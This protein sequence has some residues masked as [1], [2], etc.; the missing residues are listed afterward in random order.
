MLIRGSRLGLLAELAAAELL[1]GRLVRLS[2]APGEL[3]RAR[4]VTIERVRR[5]AAAE[6]VPGALARLRCCEPAQLAAGQYLRS[7]W[8]PTQAELPTEAELRRD[9]YSLAG[10][11]PVHL[12]E[13]YGRPAPD[14]VLDELLAVLPAGTVRYRLAALVEDPAGGWPGVI[15][16]VDELA[17]ELDGRGAAGMP[18]TVPPRLLPGLPLIRTADAADALLR[19]A[20]QPATGPYRVV[21]AVAT[22]GRT[23]WQL[24][25]TGLQLPIAQ[26]PAAAA[27]LTELLERRL[28]PLL[29]DLADGRRSDVA[30]AA[31]AA[32]P[33]PS[34]AELAA[35]IDEVRIE[36][37]RR[38]RTRDHAA[39]RL[40]P[41]RP[42][43]TAGGLPYLVAGEDGLAVVVVNALGQGPAHWLPFAAEWQPRRMLVWQPAPGHTLAEQVA[44][45]TAVLAAEGI[46]RCCLLAWCS[47]A[48]VATRFWR[49]AAQR[50]SALVLLAADFRDRQRPAELDSVYEKHLDEIFSKLIPRPKLADRMVGMLNQQLEPPTAEEA[51]FGPPAAL[52]P[53]IRAPFASGATLLRYAGQLQEFWAAEELPVAERIRCPVLSIIGDRDDIV[54]P[55][56]AAA[57]TAR[58][59]TARQL[60]V[61]GGTHYLMYE[62]PELV[63]AAL[64]EFL[65]GQPASAEC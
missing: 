59:P 24:L 25:L 45:L 48:K 26:A 61:P 64:A 4:A 10:S 21:D 13:P 60:E 63:A 32:C 51:L 46:D 8:L 18:A 58:F 38:Q 33:P 52:V 9:E 14:P 22:S 1:A 7:W 55:A 42:P 36:R 12:V 29:P 27:L 65:E 17:A 28:A 57:A 19:L 5:R 53:T 23:L 50:V 6:A 49:Q 44:D 54:A 20:E 47:G 43:V 31:R 40:G 11:A 3:A 37:Q 62:R 30:G 15:E 41:P 39:A 16:V 35:G 2:A 56:A 34:E